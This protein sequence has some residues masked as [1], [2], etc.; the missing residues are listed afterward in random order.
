MAAGGCLII[1]D[2]PLRAFPLPTLWP[3]RIRRLAH[4]PESTPPLAFLITLPFIPFLAH[5]AGPMPFN[6]AALHPW[7]GKSGEAVALFAERRGEEDLASG[8]ATAH[9][10]GAL[11]ADRA[12]LTV[13]AVRQR[14][15][16]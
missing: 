3:R 16:G 4:S 8:A 14:R 11:G 6:L 15:G 10:A 7:L 5:G 12:L 9:D 13:R 1:P 2:R